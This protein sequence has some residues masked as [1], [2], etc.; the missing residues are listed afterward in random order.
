MKTKIRYSAIIFVCLIIGLAVL[1]GCAQKEPDN[2][3][4][5]EA[6]K[7]AQRANDLHQLNNLMSL[8]SWYHCSM[9]NDIELEKIWSKRD[10]I[11][12]A[13]NSGYWVGP[14]SIKDY[15]GIPQNRE[16][17]A[18]Q[19]AWHTITSSVVEVAGDR[20]TAKGVWYTPGI[21]GGFKDGKGNFMWMFEKYGV[22][23]VFED[24]NW[25]IWH[26]H[27]YTDTTWALD[28]T[29]EAKKGMG[30]TM[31]SEAKA[32]TG[33]AKAKEA[34]PA[35]TGM[36]H[37]PDIAKQNY[38]EVTPTT[39][40]VFVPRPPEPYQTWTDTWSYTDPNEYDMFKGTYKEYKK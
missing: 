12:W 1:G 6:L 9:Q 13:Q 7:L 2:S 25:K 39:V 29:I 5:I 8:H 33:D 23:F 40:P 35:P 37:P 11:C 18:G 31:G 15:Y 14:A 32:V 27:V 34:A 26:M 24:G 20:Q 38:F 28:G 19:F 36:N 21:V 3:Q 30:E 16:N 17:L 10:D 4:A 22:D